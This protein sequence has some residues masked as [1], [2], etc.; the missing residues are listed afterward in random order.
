MGK[1]ACSFGKL[2][3]RQSTA[4]QLSHTPGSSSSQ[5][6]DGPNEV[7]LFVPLCNRLTGNLE[8]KREEDRVISSVLYLCFLALDGALY[9][10]NHTKQVPGVL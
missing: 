4:R 1:A 8:A 5:C 10:E 7:N 2:L 9:G 6:I 3:F